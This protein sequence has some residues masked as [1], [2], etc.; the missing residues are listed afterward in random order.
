VAFGATTNS[1][2]AD[3]T[4]TTAPTTTLIQRASARVLKP[5]I[6]G[7]AIAANPAKIDVD[8]KATVAAFAVRYDF[9]AQVQFE[10]ILK[11]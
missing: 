11:D 1:S 4:A 10:I 8:N 5:K 7:A 2:N 9:D 6:N 3:A